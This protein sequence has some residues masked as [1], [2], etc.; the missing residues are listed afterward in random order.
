MKVELSQIATFQ[1]MPQMIFLSRKEVRTTVPERARMLGS[2]SREAC[3]D[4]G[5]HACSMKAKSPRAVQTHALARF[6][7]IRTERLFDIM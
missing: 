3:Y 7:N 6:L 1:N 4:I 2:D 5:L